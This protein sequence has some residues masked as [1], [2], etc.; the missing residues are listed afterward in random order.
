MKKLKDQ[1]T[2]KTN[3]CVSGS[4][5]MTLSNEPLSQGS[6]HLNNRDTKDQSRK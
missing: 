3:S 6:K 1:G 5:H 4:K 2:E